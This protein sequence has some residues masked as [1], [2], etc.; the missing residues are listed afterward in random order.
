MSL[1]LADLMPPWYS[2]SKLPLLCSNIANH[3]LLHDRQI[4]DDCW[5]HQRERVVA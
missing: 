4:A 1:A 3:T 2:F 5:H